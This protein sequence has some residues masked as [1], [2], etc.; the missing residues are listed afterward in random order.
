MISVPPLSLRL[1]K[2]TIFTSITA[3]VLST[4]TF[5]S[6]V[7][8]SVTVEGGSGTSPDL[9]ATAQDGAILLEWDPVNG[10]QKYRYRYKLASE[11]WVGF[12]GTII[13]ATELSVTIDGL[14]N[15]TEYTVAVGTRK[16]DK[17]IN[18]WTEI[19]IAPTDDP[20]D[21]GG[22]DPGGGDPGGGDPPTFEL[23]DYVD[24]IG[25]TATPRI[26]SSFSK[27]CVIDVDD[28]GDL[29]VLWSV[30][31]S[32]PLNFYRGDGDGTYTEWTQSGVDKHDNHGCLVADFDNDGDLD[33]FGPAGACQGTCNKNDRLWLQKNNGKFDVK[34]WQMGPKTTDRSRDSVLTDFNNDG[35]MDI[36]ISASAVAGGQSHHRLMINQGI[37]N[38]GFWAGFAEGSVGVE[39]S[40]GNSSC[41]AADDLN[42]DGFDD[43]LVCEVN[44]MHMFVN[45]AGVNFSPYPATFNMDDVKGVSTS[46][47]N[48]DGWADLLI[49]RES[50]FEIR[51]NDQLGGFET[52]SYS[53]PLV[54]GHEVVTPD[55]DG[56][57]DLDI[58]ILQALSDQDP[59]SDAAH[60]LLLNDSG[61]A[62][63]WERVD[64]PQP[65]RGAGD[66]AE[67]LPDFMGSGH[68]AVL[69]GNGG[70]WDTKG[71]RQVIAELNL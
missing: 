48:N 36:F 41:A 50:A 21:P 6:P 66:K 56:D 55:I 17:W 57:G 26:T 49:A 27:P 8:A 53:R 1:R 22:G 9:T 68:D 25:L 37:G 29:D 24:E 58:Y 67:I 70:Q 11:E 10:A 54:F 32:E 18:D 3:L 46:D 43:L 12:S 13:P 69:I 44:R 33:I 19:D 35:W 38:D 42:N 30:H 28:D 39:Q 45:N 4:L 7:Q 16:N 62:S 64:V 59:A 51:L 34:S 15:D 61:D 60:M 65:E 52:I 40:Q 23:H 63:T 5:A 31:K 20:G 71:P 14:T 47:I 2:A